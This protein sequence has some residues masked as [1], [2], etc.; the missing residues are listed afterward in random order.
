M[1]RKKM[2]FDPLSMR[3]I[4]E[5]QKILAS[6]YKEAYDKFSQTVEGMGDGI[7]TVIV[8]DATSH[9][10]EVLLVSLFGLRGV[11]CIK[12]TI[13]LVPRE[14]PQSERVRYIRNIL[15]STVPDVT[16]LSDNAISAL[17]KKFDASL[18]CEVPLRTLS[19]TSGIAYT[20]F[21]AP[22]TS[23]CLNQCCQRYGDPDSL[24]QHHPPSTV[25]IFTFEGP[26]PATKICLKCRGCSTIY[27]YNSFGRKNAEGERFYNDV[28]EYIEVTDVT[29]CDRKVLHLYSL[30]R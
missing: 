20:G 4:F 23:S 16:T 11:E 5:R 26:K 1:S 3:T 27:N 18:D 6:T 9:S 2:K 19:S 30:L 24:Y 7:S 28:R 17:M 8:Q 25:S 21:L 29:Y 22:P 14:V 13:K 12:S 10:V 15:A